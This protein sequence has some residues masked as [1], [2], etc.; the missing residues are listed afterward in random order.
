MNIKMNEINQNQ[1]N[2]YTVSEADENQR[3]DNLLIKILKGVP[4]S[5]LYRIIRSGEVRINKARC[6]VND[7]VQ[8]GDII[9]I[10]PIRVSETSQIN[11]VVPAATFPIIFEDDYYLII[12]KPH[13]VACHGGSGVSFGVIEQLRQAKLYKFLELAHRLDKETSGILILAKKRLAL[14]ELQEQMKRNQITKEYFA[15]TLGAWR[16][17]K[18]NVKAP[19]YKYTNKD[20]E[21]RVRIDQELGQF[22]HTI[23]TLKKKYTEFSLVNADLQTGR[24]HQIR[25]HL[26]YLGFP[27]AGDDKY[28][29]FEQNKLLAK[30]GLKRMFLHAHHVKFTHPMTQ[31]TLEVNCPLPPELASFLS[32]LH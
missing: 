20:G 6:L 29:N 12:N 11:K 28:G 24:T 15:L 25:I 19:I 31:Q 1:V 14:V 5:H 7:K 18:R 23:F 10:P 30:Q 2:F 26:Q 8:L 3:L 27:I 13:G 16:D 17:E 9:R 4:K 21:R 22:S 32:K